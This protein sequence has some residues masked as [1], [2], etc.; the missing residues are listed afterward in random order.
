M[1][2]LAA[3]LAIIIVGE[4][5]AR[6]I[7]QQPRLTIAVYLNGKTG[8]EGLLRLLW[9][10]PLGAGLAEGA[11]RQQALPSSLSARQVPE[12]MR[13]SLASLLL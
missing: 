7:A 13:S 11:P 5:A 3:G 12:R 9:P 8:G 4:A 10:H 2:S 1:S 6:A